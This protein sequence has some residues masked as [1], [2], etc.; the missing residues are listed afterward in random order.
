M[1]EKGQEGVHQDLYLLVEMRLG[2]EE[3]LR[4]DSTCNSS[5]TDKSC[6][7]LTSCVNMNTL[8]VYVT[9]WCVPVASL[10]IRKVNVA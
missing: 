10:V 4:V 9:L 3:R 5:Q 7:N 1:K 2:V 6:A 8:G